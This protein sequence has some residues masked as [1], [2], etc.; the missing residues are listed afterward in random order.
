[1]IAVDQGSSEEHEI[2]TSLQV[3]M[4]M[5]PLSGSERRAMTAWLRKGGRHGRRGGQ[6]ARSLSRRQTLQS[7]PNE[8]YTGPVN[9][10]SVTYRV[11][12]LPSPVR[13]VELPSPSAV[14]SP[15]QCLSQPV[16]C[17]VP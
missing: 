5:V 8:A 17:H 2:H 1:M 10:L 16:A 9:A 3:D 6:S 4:E 12:D 11:S 7:S 15:M 13:P 14:R